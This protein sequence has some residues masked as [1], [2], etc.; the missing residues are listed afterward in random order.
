MFDLLGPAKR[1]TKAAGF[2]VNTDALKLERFEALWGRTDIL[3]QPCD[4]TSEFVAHLAT[5]GIISNKTALRELSQERDPAKMRQLAYEILDRID[6]SGSLPELALWRTALSP[7]PVDRFVERP[8]VLNY[9]VTE[10]LS[11]SDGATFRELIDIA[12]NSSGVRQGAKRNPFDVR[13][14][15]GVADTVAEMLAVG[16]DLQMEENTASIFAALAADGSRGMLIGARNEAEALALPWPADEAAR[17][18]EDIDAGFMAVVPRKPVLLD[19]QQRLGWWR[20]HPTSGETIGVMDSGFHQAG[21]ENSLLRSIHRFLLRFKINNFRHASTLR[22]MARES[23]RMSLRN[24]AALQLY[25]F[26]DRVIETL[27]FSIFFIGYSSAAD[28]E[29]VAFDAQ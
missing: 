29:L 17:V 27:Y 22:W 20:V 4:F 5:T 1:S 15:Q 16:S 25:N 21:T 6:S 24:R 14:G 26:V 10:S 12:T 8:N 9:R 11:D 28:H 2:E 3:L 13:L 7:H 23:V 19:G 18:A